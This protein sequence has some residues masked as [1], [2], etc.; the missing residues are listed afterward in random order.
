[1]MVPTADLGERGL[2]AR[3]GLYQTGKLLQT[4]AQIASL[5]ILRSALRIVGR[6]VDGLNQL[7][8]F[9]RIFAGA[10]P[11]SVGRG[12]VHIFQDGGGVLV[13]HIELLG[14]ADGDRFTPEMFPFG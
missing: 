4:A 10:P 8:G 1:M 13:T 9:E 5:P 12:G 6:P 3:V 7:H 11:L 14:I 2:D